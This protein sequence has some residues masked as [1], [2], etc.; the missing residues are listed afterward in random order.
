MSFATEMKSFGAEALAQMFEIIDGSGNECFRSV[1]DGS[2]L[3]GS[4]GQPV[5][6]G[7]D[8]KLKESWQLETISDAERE[9][10]TDVYYAGEMEDGIGP[11]GQIELHSSVGGFHSVA[12][13]TAGFGAI[14]DSEAGRAGWG[15]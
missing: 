13:T 15:K 5:K 7:G 3:T 6:E 11:K 10:S 1:R 14:V 8:A 4:H 2:E 9:V 12:L